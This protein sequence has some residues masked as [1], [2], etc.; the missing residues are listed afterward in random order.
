MTGFKLV[1]FTMTFYNRMAVPRVENW[2]NGE[3][4]VWI[5]ELSKIT[6]RTVAKI[7]MGSDKSSEQRKKQHK[8]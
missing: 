2:V 7:L 5:G 3:E 6:E 1:F 8:V 4:Q